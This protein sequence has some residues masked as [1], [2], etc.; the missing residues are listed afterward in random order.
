[1]VRINLDLYKLFV[2][3]DAPVRFEFESQQAYDRMVPGQLDVDPPPSLIAFPKDDPPASA[4]MTEALTAEAAQKEAIQQT[5]K[6]SEAI[7][8]KETVTNLVVED[9]VGGNRVARRST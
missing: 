8:K 6:M 2:P 7:E 9:K 5:P 4:V 3:L 1:M